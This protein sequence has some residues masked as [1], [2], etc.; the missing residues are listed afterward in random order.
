MVVIPNR[1]MAG[2]LSDIPDSVP[3]SKLV[4]P[5]ELFLHTQRAL[6]SWF[7][8]ARTN[9][10]RRS[11]GTI[12]SL[13]MLRK[14]DGTAGTTLRTIP[15]DGTIK[16]ARERGALPGRAPRSERRE[17]VRVPPDGAARA[18]TLVPKDPGDDADVPACAGVGARDARGVDHAGADAQRGARG[19]VRW[20]GACGD[21][22]RAWGAG[23][24]VLGEP[25]AD[26]W[27]GAG[28]GGVA[29]SVR[30]GGDEDH[31]VAAESQGGVRGVVW[32]DCGAGA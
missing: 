25:G 4:L 2:Y 29:E 8:Q 3:L 30:G 18:A 11:V 24:V 6:L 19:G 27:G 26:A 14:Q 12:F 28:E 21:R 16:A 1:D 13:L 7:S 17:A 20:D 23:D 31:A 9:R 32:G 5:G 10:K 15:D 22:A